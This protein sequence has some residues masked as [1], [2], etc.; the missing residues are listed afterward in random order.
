[1]PQAEGGLKSFN[2][3]FT[4]VKA[5]YA[6][7]QAAHNGDGPVPSWVYDV[8]RAAGLDT[9]ELDGLTDVEAYNLLKKLLPG[10]AKVNM[11]RCASVVLVQVWC[12]CSMRSSSC[13]A[14][15]V[16]LKWY[17]WQ[18]GVSGS[19]QTQADCSG[20]TVAG[21]GEAALQCLG[22]FS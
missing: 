10:G 2:N 20:G 19:C 1:M 22:L 3:W 8:Y 7:F 14:D 13:Q 11:W 5:E 9:D 6:A 17:M 4:D 16:L 21:G 15:N 18:L 12:W